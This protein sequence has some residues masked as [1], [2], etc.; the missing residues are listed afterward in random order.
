MQ[1]V[2]THLRR[3]QLGDSKGFRW[4]FEHYHQKVFSYAL[5]F[6]KNRQVAEELTSDVFLKLW[7]KRS[8]IQTEGSLQQLLLTITRGM[9]IDHLRKVARNSRSREL[10]WLN[11]EVHTPESIAE[12][13]FEED[14]AAI[15]EAI[16]G[17]PPKRRKVFELRYKEELS[18]QQIAQMLDVS[19]NTV[20]VHLN[21]ATKYLR[22]QLEIHYDWAL[23]LFIISIT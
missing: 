20:K 10:Y 13:K 1:E 18:Y 3:L 12:E 14:L 16:K 17:L 23:V 8:Q 2:K 6:V 21:K 15:N 22:Q 5:R 7:E 19:P 9:A 11:Y 4:L